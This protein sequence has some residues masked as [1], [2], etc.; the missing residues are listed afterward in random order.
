L[1]LKSK[2]GRYKMNGIALSCWNSAYLLKHS[3][4][5]KEWNAH[6]QTDRQTDNRQCSLNGVDRWAQTGTAV[7][8]TETDVT[9]LVQ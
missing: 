7:Q 3:K 6:A 2:M 5:K 8:V 1:K 4:Q 9:P